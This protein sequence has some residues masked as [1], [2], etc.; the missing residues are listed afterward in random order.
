M[1]TA[2]LPVAAAIALP[3]LTFPTGAMVLQYSLFIV[4]VA[5]RNNMGAGALFVCFLYTI[6]AFRIGIKR[7]TRATTVRNDWVE[8]DRHK[9]EDEKFKNQQKLYPWQM[10]WFS[11][12]MSTKYSVY[13]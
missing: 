8:D 1:A 11:R 9:K 3:E 10:L 4:F 5:Y 12:I 2:I 6:P 7:T 13:S